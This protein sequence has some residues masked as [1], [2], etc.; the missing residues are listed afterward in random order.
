M[1]KKK[2]INVQIL[3]W[4][5]YPIEIRLSATSI[6]VIADFFVRRLPNFFLKNFLDWIYFFMIASLL[7]R[8]DGNIEK[9]I[10][11]DNFYLFGYKIRTKSVTSCNQIFIVFF[12]VFPFSIVKKL[13]TTFFQRKSLPILYKVLSVFN[14]RLNRE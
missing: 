12:V 6:T 4:I 13:K 14:N 10:F 2:H 8:K 7:K 1:R 5:T 9:V 11:L 3:L